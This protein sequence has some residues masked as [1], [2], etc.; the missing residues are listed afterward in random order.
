MTIVI[1]QLVE[2]DPS[3]VGPPSAPEPGRLGRF[4]RAHRDGVIVA[5][6][7][8][9]IVVVQA[10]NIG[11]F[12][13]VSDDEGTY[14]AQ[15][16]AVQHGR[17]LAHY[18]YWYDHPPLGWLQIAMLS[19]IPALFDH[20]TQVVTHAR[21]IM[22]PVTAVAAALVYV[23]ARRID[24]PRW[25]A[26]LAT[27]IFGLSPLS[28]TMQRE[29]YLDNFAVVWI[30]AAFVLALS[31][32]RHLWH[33]VAAGLCAATAVL[34]KETIIAVIPALIM[35]MWR[36]TDRSTRKFAIVGFLA[37]FSL[38]G[39]QYVLYAVLKGELLPGANHNSLIGAIQYQLQR[40]GSGNIL[41]TGSVSNMTMHWWLVR[42]PILVY[43]GIAASFAALFVKR[44]REIGVAA[45]ILMAVAVRPN[46]YLPAMY[47]IQA[48]P[49]F[50]LAI[51]GIA[52]TAVKGIRTV[53]LPRRLPRLRIGRVNIVA[54]TAVILA[55]LVAP[56]WATGDATADTA[57]SNNNYFAAS[58]WIRTHIKDPAHTRIVV[59]DALWPDMVGA[60]F[61]PGLGAIWFYKV[62]LDPAVTKTLPH[63]WRDI[64]YVVSTSIIRQ[65][66]NGLPTVRAAM[67]HSTAV[68]TFG[69][70]DQ[71]VQ[72]LRVN[73][74]GGGK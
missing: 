12:P 13:T 60:G 42:D 58:A 14:L 73:G 44:L 26:A 51:A 50:A 17:G 61:Q 18:S 36:G 2:A 49:F 31:P 27:V 57:L 38:I 65:D 30:L 52:D 4:I 8:V 35:A 29:I 39:L 41:R 7:V 9:A 1:E 47:V 20:G 48:I 22:L 63:G 53:P 55:G 43:A 62:D 69:S 64:N 70:G 25:A 40:G 19:W 59:D 67:A 37:A 16:W 24:L 11:N 68:A 33:H 45:V 46:G 72:I 54:F 71:S 6:L 23:V 3:R 10:V 21:V 74:N 32:R 5:V 66:P 28:V 34:S 56:Q 15:A